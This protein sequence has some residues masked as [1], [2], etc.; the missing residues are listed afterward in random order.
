MNPLELEVEGFGPYADRQVVPFGRLDRV[1]VISGDTGAGKTTLFD[2][3]S[4]AL[5]GRPLGTRDR[6]SVRSHFAGPLAPT[7]VRFRFRCE[8]RTW[9]IVRAPYLPRRAKRGDSVVVE[10]SVCL[11]EIDASGACRPVAAKPAEIDRR[12][13]EDILKLTHDEF[14]KIL[15]LPQGEFQRFLEMET[16]ERSEILEKA[17]PTAD[18]RE[19]TRLAREGSQQVRKEVDEKQARLEE[20]RKDFDPDAFPDTEARLLAAVEEARAIEVDHSA[21]A[22]RATR[23][24]DAAITLAKRLGALAAAVEVRAELERRRA[25]VTAAGARLDASRRA[26]RAVAAVEAEATLRLHCATARQTL[27]T[28]AGEVRRLEAEQGG[29]RPAFEALEAQEAGFR[30]DDRRVDALGGRIG[31]LSALDEASKEVRRLDLE[32]TAAA[33]RRDALVLGVVA[34]ETALTGLTRVSQAHE[35]TTRAL[36]VVHDRVLSIEALR[37]P[38]DQADRW[39]TTGEAELARNL[40]RAEQGRI[41]AHLEVE[42]ATATLDAAR[43]RLE[44]QAAVRLAAALQEG[45]PC[46]V[47][48][49]TH[50]PRPATGEVPPDDLRAAV[51]D[52]EARLESARA[53][54]S[55]QEQ[56]LSAARKERDLRAEEAETALGRL[57]AAGYA[58]PGAWQEARIEAEREETRLKAED[59]AMRS[60]LATRGAREEA[61][62][63]VRSAHAQA[64]AA[65]ASVRE[66]EAAARGA[67]EAAR[68]RVGEVEEACEALDAARRDRDALEA[69][70]RAGRAAAAQTR[71]RW[72]ENERNLAGRRA[73]CESTRT[74]LAKAEQRLVEASAALNAVL[75]EQ[76]FESAEE[77]REAQLPSQAEAA[78][79]ATVKD[80]TDALTGVDARIVDLEEA[81]GGRP[82]PDLPALEAERDQAETVRKAATEERTRAEARVADLR[83]VKARHDEI[84]AEIEALHEHSAGL[85]ALARDLE[86]SNARRLDFSTWVL[87]WWLDRVLAR[88]SGRLQKLSEGRYTFVLKPE[89]GDRRKRSGLELD[90]FDAHTAERRDVRTLSGGEKFLA[91]LSL[92]LGLADVIQERAGGIEL[93]TLFIDEGF[94]S[95]DAGAMD[96]ALQVVDEIGANRQVGLISHVEAVGRVIPCHVLVEKAPDGS[97]VRV[98][99]LGGT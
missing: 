48:G 9:E 80:W 73:S 57:G 50:H 38:A 67:L 76:G 42:A 33:E 74:D 92:A 23:A 40:E 22:T 26:T 6:N 96:R 90:V 8:G 17:F 25:E 55:A 71:A 82:P 81:I 21:A 53:E 29:L 39:A 16:A 78:I 64:Q 87:T 43:A 41:R 30:E 36:Q 98:E 62:A 19:I 37:P 46:P 85:L 61:V 24:L 15:V 89:S 27:E 94:G 54:R 75:A 83:R 13:E 95:L 69:R 47:C 79:E 7:R 18:H 45:A 56:I 49:S 14:S 65:L 11:S 52:A 1:F 59:E 4:F 60:L 5:Y 2:A 77:V 91:S 70:I 3:I 32:A 63:A 99:A 72:E 93:D 34:A 12:L 35:E 88:A 44:A 86:G 10:S 28:L 68:T 51:T 66:A 97:R 20:V 84:L 58:S 31:D